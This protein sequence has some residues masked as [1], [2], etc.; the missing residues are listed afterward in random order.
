M[1]KNGI[2]K[3][4]ILVGVGKASSLLDIM[5]EKFYKSFGLTRVQFFALHLTVVAGEEGMPLSALGEEMSVSKANITTLIDRMETNGFVKR[6]QDQNDRRSSKVCA[7]TEGLRIF[8]ITQPRK[9]KFVTDV[10][11]F[12]T[13]NELKRASELLKKFEDELAKI[14]EDFIKMEAENEI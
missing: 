1:D 3:N 7:T 12:L 10:F 6:V 4:E 13:E 5:F 14:N 2:L 8:N 11:S 9:E